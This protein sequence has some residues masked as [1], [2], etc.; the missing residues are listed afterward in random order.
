MLP[1]LIFFTLFQ[2][3]NSS[4]H[5]EISS[6][7]YMAALHFLTSF[8][9]C[10]TKQVRNQL[11]LQIKLRLEDTVCLQITLFLFEYVCLCMCFPGVL[12]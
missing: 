6:V 9:Q 11:I 1:F 10:K 3:Q 8:Q 12:L 7:I 2:L 4:V 5:K